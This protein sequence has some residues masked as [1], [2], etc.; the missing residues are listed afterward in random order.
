MFARRLLARLGPTLPVA[1]QALI[2]A[3]NFLS[4]V[5]VAREMG[6]A[7]FGVWV[8]AVLL[9]WLCIPI[10]NGLM[11]QPMIVNSAGLD[12]EPYRRYLRAYLP[13]QVGFIAIS[14]T[15]VLVVALLWPPVRS[16][17]LPL[18]VAAAAL[19]AQDCCR[20]ILYAR[21]RMGAA[22]VTNVINSDL[23]AALLLVVAVTTDLSLWT[24]VWI[25]AGTSI[26]AML[27]AVWTIRDLVARQGDDVRTVAREGFAMGKWSAAS[28]GIHVASGHI[29]AGFV[30]EVAGIGAAAGLGAVLQLVGPLNLFLRPMQNYFLPR[31]AA[32][33]ARG[34]EGA[35]RRALWDV[36]RLSGPPY[37]LYVGALIVAPSTVLALVYGP[38]YSQYGDA[39]LFAAL[40]ALLRFPAHLLD[41][42]VSARR[43]PRYLP[44]ARAGSAVTLY[45]V[46]F[47]LVSTLGLTGAGITLAL[48]VAV[49]LGIIGVFVLRLRRAATAAGAD[50]AEAAACQAKTIP[51]LLPPG[52][53][54]DLPTRDGRHVFVPAASLATRYQGSALYPA[55]RPTA[56]AYRAALRAWTTVGWA[57]LTHAVVRSPGEDWQLGDLLAADVPGLATAA[58]RT[59]TAPAPKVSIQLMDQHGRVLAFAKYATMPRARAL[60]ANEARMLQVLPEGT[61]PRLIRYTP[62]VDGDLLV[63]STIPGR[64]YPATPV[65][66]EAQL[67]L[68]ARLTHDGPRYR[69][70]DHPFVVAL[71]Q[72]AHV[73]RDALEQAID[74]LGTSEWP[75]VWMHG[76][77]AFFN[78]NS[79]RAT[80]LPF[81]W[82]CGTEEGFPYVDAAHWS[83]LVYRTILR[84]PAAESKAM[85]AGLLGTYLPT[86]L[87]SHA[88]AIA[89]L[90]GL[91]IRAVWAPREDRDD[92]ANRWI[93]EFIAAPA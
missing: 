5:I 82:E 51:P 63:Q 64:S 66:D 23:Q 65:L 22:M 79:W 55:F 10:Q 73:Q 88:A 85:V 59:G 54:I 30:A 39:L 69:A 81:D 75:T 18:V 57:R 16:L 92:A 42:E 47:Y 26:A 27:V 76:D 11:L 25:V 7:D 40:A 32:A 29:Y 71:G 78:V 89:T 14:S 38:E 37:L 70:A 33:W 62:F 44:W 74:R 50:H 91:R 72:S 43:Q 80:C 53:S 4:G 56:R 1:D 93:E 6:P 86:H 45:T 87:R 17:A 41:V 3:G 52:E 13:L 21:R 83:T 35:L 49:Q 77:F 31:A 20:R 84:R 2:S 8:V 90:C 12:G 61:A 36:V 46:G 48:A 34:G 68:L 67:A 9:V 28:E 15:L 24:A 19:Q 60:L 58:I